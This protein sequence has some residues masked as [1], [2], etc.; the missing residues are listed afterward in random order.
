[1]D[2]S[3]LYDGQVSSVGRS[4][5]LAG[6]DAF[7]KDRIR[8]SSQVLLRWNM[9]TEAVDVRLGQNGATLISADGKTLEM[10]VEGLDGCVMKTWDAVPLW[11]SE[12]PSY[13]NFVGF[14]A[15]LEGGSDYEIIT[16]LIPN[17]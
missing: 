9:C 5:W 14:E 13:Q 10:K 7:I 3:S 1:M 15:T 17:R 8:T 4:V 16:K 11:P 6:K 12:T 2:L